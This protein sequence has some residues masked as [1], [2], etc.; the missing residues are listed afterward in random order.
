MPAAPFQ[1]VR[2][3][4]SRD[5]LSPVYRYLRFSIDGRFI[6][7]FNQ[8]AAYA[9]TA[10]SALRGFPRKRSSIITQ[11][12]LNAQASAAVFPDPASIVANPYAQLKRVAQ[13]CNQLGDCLEALHA[14]T[15]RLVQTPPTGQAFG[16][17]KAGTTGAPVNRAYDNE[18]LLEP[19][20]SALPPMENLLSVIIPFTS[21][22]AVTSSLGL[23]VQNRWIP[24]ET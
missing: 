20:F 19:I 7:N 3:P 14:R 5:T 1:K 6:I 4:T 18:V 22:F 24:D 23:G 12:P 9:A 16:Y 21:P 10:D 2:C 13:Q 15:S 11:S 8:V 17:F